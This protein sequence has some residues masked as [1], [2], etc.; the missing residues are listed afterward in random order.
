MK[1]FLALLLVMILA[2]STLALSATA[3]EKTYNMPPMNTTDPIVLTM[4]HHHG[5]AF[6]LLMDAL[7]KEFNER[8]PNITIE[9]VDTSKLGADVDGTMTELLAAGELPDFGIGP[10]W[11]PTLQYNKICYDLTEFVENDEEYLG[12]KKSIFA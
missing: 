5:D 2:M 6:T 11:A 9:I 4:R 8:Y 12:L 1:K 7:G 10:W 3:E